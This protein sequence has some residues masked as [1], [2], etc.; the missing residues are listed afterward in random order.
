MVFDLKG[1][2]VTDEG[3]AVMVIMRVE[4]MVEVVRPAAPTPLSPVISGAG[5]TTWL[6]KGTPL[7]PVASAKGQ[8]VVE[9]TKVSVVT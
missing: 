1:Q 2:S 3:Q 8:T 7:V 5:G 6:V 9:T 4:K